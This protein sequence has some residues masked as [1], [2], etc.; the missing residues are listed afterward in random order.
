[1]FIQTGINPDGLDIEHQ[2]KIEEEIRLQN[3]NE[4]YQTALEFN[5]EAFGRVC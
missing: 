4:N 3:I 5:P 1:M 2:R